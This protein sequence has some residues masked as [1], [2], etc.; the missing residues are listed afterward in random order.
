MISRSYYFLLSKN[1]WTQY[2]TGKNNAGIEP[3]P[4]MC[5]EMTSFT[6]S[7]A[8]SI[9]YLLAVNELFMMRIVNVVYL[10]KIIIF[11]VVVH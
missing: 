1:D 3:M 6:T 9:R 11:Y 2:F 8:G 5:F 7:Y 10:L 4:N